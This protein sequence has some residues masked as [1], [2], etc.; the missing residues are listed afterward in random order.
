[1][2]TAVRFK[3]EG[4]VCWMKFPS[5]QTSSGVRSIRYPVATGEGRATDVVF[6]LP[7]EESVVSVGCIVML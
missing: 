6:Y 4:K 5:V 3:D 2:V 1:M 7:L